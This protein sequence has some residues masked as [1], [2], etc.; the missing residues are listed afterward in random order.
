[1]KELPALESARR[2][3]HHLLD[4]DA[5]KTWLHC[6]TPGV[7]SKTTQAASVPASADTIGSV[8]VAS[9][10]TSMNVTC[11]RPDGTCHCVHAVQLP[12]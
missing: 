7:A 11:A 8:P 2:S 1:M 12:F 5:S 10:V 3:D 6:R 4:G 9:L